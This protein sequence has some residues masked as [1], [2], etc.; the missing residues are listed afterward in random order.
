MSS[1]A[2]PASA[3]ESSGHKAITKLP[4]YF[5]TSCKQC[6][7]PTDAFF[8]CFEEHAVMLDERDVATA[9]TS[10]QHCQ[11]EL[12]GYMSCMDHYFAT[13]DKPWWKVW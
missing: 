10:L 11:P 8:R 9:K 4:P 1:T 2:A 5:P 3:L 6:A 12:H 13:K 7:A